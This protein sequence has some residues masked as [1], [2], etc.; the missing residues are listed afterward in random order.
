MLDRG[1]TST[2][3]SER[4]A[5]ELHLDGETKELSLTTLDK[6]DRRVSSFVVSLDVAAIGDFHSLERVLTRPSIPIKRSN[7]GQQCELKQWRL[8]RELEIPEID[9]T[10]NNPDILM[11]RELRNGDPYRTRTLLGWTWEEWE[12]LVN[13]K[14]E[15]SVNDKKRTIRLG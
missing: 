4:L 6:E 5:D 14:T 13:E 3:C 8:L 15:M 1:S 12:T 7:I 10:S 2:F 9:A 11:P